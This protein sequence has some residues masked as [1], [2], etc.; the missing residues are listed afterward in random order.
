M[1]TDSVTTLRHKEQLTTLAAVVTKLSTAIGDLDLS[2]DLNPEVVSNVTS[3]SNYDLDGM[4]NSPV[5]CIWLTAFL[6]DVL[7]PLVGKGGPLETVPDS[8]LADDPMARVMLRLLAMQTEVGNG[9]V[10]A[11]ISGFL[12]GLS[13]TID[14]MKAG[15]AL[16]WSFVGVAAIMQL[17]HPQFTESLLDV[18]GVDAAEEA[19]AILAGLESMP[20][21]SSED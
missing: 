4:S 2:A 10:T 6:T 12:S 20:E 19:E 5:E 13:N 9:G 3:Q 16:L 21:K 1:S 11:W 18:V 14:P 17:N 15:R 8:M 7:S